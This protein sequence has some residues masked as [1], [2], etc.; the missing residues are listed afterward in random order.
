M[1]FN[2]PLDCTSRRQDTALA[3]EILRLLREGGQGAADN[4]K[5]VV[6]QR[7]QRSSSRYGVPCGWAPRKTRV[8]R[9]TK[10]QEGD[11]LSLLI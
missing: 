2:S 7:P 8:S 3:A 11:S 6:P 1:L 5:S 4:R 9:S 10:Y